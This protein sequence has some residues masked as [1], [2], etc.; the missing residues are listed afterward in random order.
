MYQYQLINRTQG[1][2]LTKTHPRKDKLVRQSYTKEK[3]ICSNLL[4]ICRIWQRDE[5]RECT[6]RG[7][8]ARTKVWR[9]DWAGAMAQQWGRE[10]GPETGSG[11]RNWGKEVLVYRLG[12]IIK[13]LERQE[14]DVY[15]DMAGSRELFEQASNTKYSQSS[16]F[17]DFVF[18]NLPAW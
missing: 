11:S 9:E 4:S 12:Q 6:P 16:S 5:R 1:S 13:T 7:E 8:T 3:E 18:V 2:T 14:S 10:A 17:T 15:I